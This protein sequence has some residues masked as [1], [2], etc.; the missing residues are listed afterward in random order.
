MAVLPRVCGRHAAGA[1]VPAVRGRPPRECE[2]V[3]AGVR[4]VPG[5]LGGVPAV[6]GGL[7][8][9]VYAGAAAVS[10]LRA[11]RVCTVTEPNIDALPLVNGSIEIDV[12]LRDTVTGRTVLHRSPYGCVDEYGG[13]RYFQSYWWADGNMGCDC[14]RGGLCEDNGEPVLDGVIGCSPNGQNRIVIDKI[15]PRDRPDDV[16]YSDAERD[17]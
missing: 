12:Y 15:T 6:R 14:N 2:A 1:G 5:R 10:E 11:A 9:R 16:L 8:P 13:R 7:V 17:S 3:E 4:G